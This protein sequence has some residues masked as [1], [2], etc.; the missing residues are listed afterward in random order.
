MELTRTDAVFS[1]IAMVLFLCR[2]KS[3]RNV[4]KIYGEFFW[5]NM[6]NTCAKIHRRGWASGPQA[7][8]PRPPP[9][10]R[11]AGLWGPRG[12]A[13]P[14][15]SSIYSLSPGKKSREKISS[16]FTI[17][18]RRHLLFFIWRADL[19]SV[20]G[21]GEGKSSPS[22]SSTFLHLQFHDALHRS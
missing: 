10:P 3:S 16:R 2:N 17:R 12:S 21:S 8:R 14:N 9:W 19:E 15:L 22:S 4:L 13:A 7:H 20:L 11:L 18:R 6:K 1:R 5:N